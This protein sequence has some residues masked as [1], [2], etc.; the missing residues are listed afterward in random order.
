MGL[1]SWVEQGRLL[2]VADKGP[3]IQPEQFT[4]LDDGRVLGGDGSPI[5]GLR[6][7]AEREE[8]EAG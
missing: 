7:E 5:P 2:N 3:D 4:A 8:R 1:I 6:A